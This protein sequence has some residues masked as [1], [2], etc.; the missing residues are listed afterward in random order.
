MPSDVSHF[1]R[2]ALRQAFEGGMFALS[3]EENDWLSLM[4]PEEYNRL[5]E[6]RFNKWYEENAE[7][8]L[9]GLSA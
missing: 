4:D 9:R 6:E 8:L 1:D 3:E 5:A 2:S 7:S